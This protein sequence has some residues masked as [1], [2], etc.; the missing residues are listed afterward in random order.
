MSV[1]LVM[2]T[3]ERIFNKKTFLGDKL[4]HVIE[5]RLTYNY[6][7]GVNSFLNT[8]RFDATDLLSDT[9]EVE[10][11][12]TNRIYAKK[13]DAVSEIFTWELYQKF[14][15]D[16]A[17]GGAVVAGQRNIVLSEIDMTGFAFLS[18]PRSYSPLVSVLRASPRA[19]VNIQWQADYDPVRR[20]IVNSTFSTDLRVKKYFVSMG[21]NIVRPNPVI[22]PA[23]NQIRATFGF[24]D[25]N[26]K[27]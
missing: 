20:L 27:G 15:F 14:Y 17:F 11:G 7:T 18:G 10:I 9:N 4:K 16:P 25:P 8:P 13:G 1:D 26:R 21:N 23:A 6:V 5:P 3:I 19:G 22:A 12:L 2:P 24:G